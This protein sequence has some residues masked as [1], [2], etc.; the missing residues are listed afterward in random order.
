MYRRYTRAEVDSVL[1][2]LRTGVSARELARRSGIPRGTIGYWHRNPVR[3]RI[4]PRV[5]GAAWCPLPAPVYCYLLGMYLGDG[6]IVARGDSATIR[7]TLDERYPAIVREATAA[8]LRVFPEGNV[9]HYTYGHANRV[10]LQLS[11]PGVIPAFPQHGQ[12]RKHLRRI[13]L[14]SWQLALTRRYPRPLLRGLIHS[15]GCRCINRFKTLLPSGRTAEYQ[16]VRYFFTNL[17]TDIQR[18]F[19]EHCELLDIR[20]SQSSFKNVSVAHRESVAILDSFIGPKT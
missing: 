6:H 7:L 11:H 16:Y 14:H 12:G 17:S 3:K 4:R 18:I 1:A 10:L 13:R 9:G 5:R 19:S 2:T 20:C 15:D 8:L